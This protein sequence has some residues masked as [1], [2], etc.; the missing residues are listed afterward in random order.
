MVNASHTGE[1]KRSEQMALLR[2]VEPDRTLRRDG[3][4]PVRQKGERLRT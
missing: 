3:N 4:H 2:G 1:F